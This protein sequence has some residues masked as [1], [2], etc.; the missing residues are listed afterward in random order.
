M[1]YPDY[2]ELISKNRHYRQ[3]KVIVLPNNPDD[4]ESTSP[5]GMYISKMLNIHAK[6]GWQVKA[7]Y[8]ANN[9]K[10]NVFVLEKYF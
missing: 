9:F 6:Q 8:P 3:I 5:D 7:A 2:T 4:G 1:E 10:E